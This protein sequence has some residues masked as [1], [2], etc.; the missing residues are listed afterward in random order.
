MA[1]APMYRPRVTQ[2][3]IV[4]QELKR[5]NQI[6]NGPLAIN[7]YVLQPLL[8]A[9]LSTSRR[10]CEMVV[11][12]WHEFLQGAP[13]VGAR[14]SSSGECLTRLPCAASSYYGHAL[15][16][17]GAVDY[18]FEREAISWSC[19]C[20]EGWPRG[21]RVRISK[22]E[23]GCGEWASARHREERPCAL[24]AWRGEREAALEYIKKPRM[25]DRT[26]HASAN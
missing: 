10:E 9:F 8:V 22:P 7:A 5:V 18:G 25:W 11:V 15:Y 21:T 19:A 23:G 26:P 20:T 3:I 13:V 6:A 14:C 2:A 24:S 12:S 4:K 17:S 1:C 16:E